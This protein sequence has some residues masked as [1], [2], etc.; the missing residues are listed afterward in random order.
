M[1]RL[2]RFRKGYEIKQVIVGSNTMLPSWNLVLKQRIS[3]IEH[4]LNDQKWFSTMRKSTYQ[5]I[6]VACFNKKIDGSQLYY[7]VRIWNDRNHFENT[8]IAVVWDCNAKNLIE[9]NKIQFCGT[10]SRCLAPKFY[11]P[12]KR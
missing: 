6:L 10:A 3:A 1:I 11:Y 7:S 12:V 4:W 8:G 5:I 2:T 9:E